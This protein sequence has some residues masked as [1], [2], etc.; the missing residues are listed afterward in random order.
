MKVRYIYSACIEIETR[1]LRILYD[2]W[3]SDG[4]YDGSW[5]HFP[6]VKNPLRK[7]KEPDLIYISHIHPDHYD[8]AFLK[9][10][11]YKYGKKPV[12]ISNHK[13][14]YLFLKSKFDGIETTPINYKKIKNTNI[15]I[16]ANDTGSDNDI[17]SALIVNCS[18]SNRTV[19][20]LND[21]LWNDNHSL[22]VKKIINK[23]SKKLDLLA[24]GYAGAG[25]YPQTYYDVKG[26]KKKLIKLATQKKIEFFNRY[27]KYCNYFVSK[28]H[29]PFAGKYILGGKL[30]HLN[31][32]RGVPDPIEVTKFD[33][34]AL[35]LDDFGKGIIDLNSNKITKLRTKK[36]SNLKINKINS[37]RNN[38]FDYEKEINIEYNK[39]NFLRLF[40]KAYS[41]ALNKSELK[42]DYYF[43]FKIYDKNKLKTQLFININ[44]NK[45]EIGK[46]NLN[47]KFLRPV[48]EIII[49][50]KY[51]FGL[52]TGIYH[53]NNAE[54]RKHVFY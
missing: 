49:D 2:P 4:I 11:F 5:Y 51:L 36:Y 23:Y 30:S 7:I 18:F 29:L 32:Y 17:D 20:N 38:K 50:Y 42:R 6:E 27:K 53:W 41:N 44:K 14:N 19:L 39:I 37:I 15:H 45:K 12:L 21:N 31:K 16:I 43:V 40:Y 9:K 26:E 24:L 8:P 28:Y 54:G 13:K 33:K 46:T 22:K 1:D 25:P 48:S 47:N 52:L 3:F 10:L 35:I 34:K